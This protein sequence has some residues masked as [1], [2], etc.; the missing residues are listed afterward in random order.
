MSTL[1]VPEQLEK[2][3]ERKKQLT[4]LHE[5]SLQL[6]ADNDEQKNAEQALYRVVVLEF[7]YLLAQEMAETRQDLPAM[8]LFDQATKLWYRLT[9]VQTKYWDYRDNGIIHL[10]DAKAQILEHSF[11]YLSYDGFLVSPT[12]KAKKLIEDF[13]SRLDQLRSI[14]VINQMLE[15][16]RVSLNGV[17]EGGV[18]G[19]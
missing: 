4:K 7:T 18:R 17:V 5:R 11:G 15:M 2:E 1:K 14:E 9:S 10:D 12:E 16:G 8:E 6:M 3:E 19:D 13:K